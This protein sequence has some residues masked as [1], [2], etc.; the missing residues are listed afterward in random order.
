MAALEESF[1]SRFSEPG[2]ER[3]EPER[4]GDGPPNICSQNAGK[5]PAAGSPQ[6]RGGGRESRRSA[7]R[8]SRAGGRWQKENMRLEVIGQNP[9]ERTDP[10]NQGVLADELVAT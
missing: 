2:A 8:A 5:Q 9:W 10:R 1:G 7:G 3:S 4:S 6:G